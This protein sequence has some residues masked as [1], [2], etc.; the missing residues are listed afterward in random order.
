MTNLEKQWPQLVVREKE[1]LT[2]N[3]PV[4]GPLPVGHSGN[5]VRPE[6]AKIAIKF[7]WSVSLDAWWK[8]R[9]QWPTGHHRGVGLT[10]LWKW[11]ILTTTFLREFVFSTLGLWYMPTIPA[12]QASSLR[13]LEFPLCFLG[14]FH[15]LYLTCDLQGA[16][17]LNMFL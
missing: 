11:R 15:W 10:A 12:W 9:A 2:V 1:T 16:L 8:R 7:K 6:T 17:E 5:A 4:A 14:F 3:F 13:T